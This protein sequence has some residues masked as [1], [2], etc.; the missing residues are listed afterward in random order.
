M[1]IYPKGTPV[2]PWFG[3]AFVLPFW[4]VYLIL[5]IWHSILD[6]FTLQWVSLQRVC[7]CILSNLP[8]TVWMIV[9][10]DSVHPT[11]R[12]LGL[13]EICMIEEHRERIIL[14][15]P[16]VSSSTVTSHIATWIDTTCHCISAL[17]VAPMEITQ[18][19]LA[20]PS[21]RTTVWSE[22]DWRGSWKRKWRQAQQLQIATKYSDSNLGRLSGT[23]Y[24]HCVVTVSWG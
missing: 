6:P 8:S 3:Y 23:H 9:P 21:P 16:S 17:K 22:F 11:G 14:Q 18:R 13:F 2:I 19:T 4:H 10:T 5:S 1:Y 7:T 24:D 20:C 12:R 15:K